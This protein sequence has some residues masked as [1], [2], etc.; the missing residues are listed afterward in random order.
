M[1]AD[2][3]ASDGGA[4]EEYGE[5]RPHRRRRRRRRHRHRPVESDG[6]RLVAGVVVGVVALLF[7]AGA[8]YYFKASSPTETALA[9]LRSRPLIGA[10]M[11]DNP[12]AEARLR[13]AIEEELASPSQ[14]GTTRPLVL[15]AD[16]KRQYV[17]PALRS[18]D[19]TT[20]LAAVAARAKLATHLQKTNPSAC[21]EF[22]TGGIQ[23]PERLDGEGQQLLRNVQIA[24]EAAYKN[25]RA[26]GKPLPMPTRAEVVDQLRQAGFQQL[27]F[28]RL[29]N[30]TTLSNEIACEVELKV[31]QVPLKL[32][33]DKRGPFAR[34]VLSNN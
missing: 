21:R 4:T 1:T 22:A 26:N 9:E 20:A 3:G 18:A 33:A 7:A 24:L 25:G 15:I 10:M 19:D 27:D 11:A 31:D 8:W 28:D 2:D 14:D 12:E 29:N 34:F 16:L 6:N 32:S 30:F 17:L 13:A 5:E 23:R